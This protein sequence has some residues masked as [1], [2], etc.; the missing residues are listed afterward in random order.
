MTRYLIT[1]A[2]P[3]I[4]GVK[5]LGNLVGSMLPADVYARYLRGRGRNVFYLCAT[6]EHGTPAELA[7]AEEGVPVSEYCKRQY[8]IQ[9]AIYQR[10]DLSFDYF[11]RTS[12]AHNHRTTQYI[13]KSLRDRGYIDRRKIKQLYS[14]S[15]G[16]FLPDRYVMGT[17]PKCGDE[18]ARGD[19]CDAC[20]SLL[21][22]TDLIKPRSAVS[23]SFD[24]KMRETEH[25]YLK[26]SAFEP[27]LRE[28]VNKHSNWPLLTRSVALKWLN[29][30]LRARC[31]TRDLQW[32]VP[33]PEEN[34]ANKVFY[35]WFDAPIG[36]ISA[37]QEWAESIGEPEAW[38]SW[39]ES[40]TDVHYT[41]FM[42]KDNLPFHTVFFPAMLMGTGESW[43][44]PD[45]IKAFNWLT[46]EG[47]KFS[48]R[49]NRGVFLDKAIDLFPADYWRWML[50]AAAPESSDS[51]FTWSEF[52]NKVNK[53][54]NDRLG[55]QV[56][57]VLKLCAKQFGTIVPEGGV[58][59][60]EEVELEA[61]T[62]KLIAQIEQHYEK[63]EFRY[64]TQKI[65]ELWSLGNNYFDRCV[66]WKKELKSER[67]AVVLRTSINLLR[68][69]A[70]V[71]EPII[72]ESSHVIQACLGE[73]KDAVDVWKEQKW[74]RAISSGRQFN[75]PESLFRKVSDREVAEF[76]MRFAGLSK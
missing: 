41:Q 36:Y 10:F 73:G 42:A 62:G 37:A 5:H 2:L 67:R 20:L 31:I 30:G 14:P 49:G 3:Y 66:P 75:V 53:D 60:S 35:V 70:L 13:Y 48:T 21:E 33:V 34:M 47:D 17:C 15:D 52:Q 50:L 27:L 16:R 56:F 28:W 59:G 24:L 12:S 29:E 4:N 68:L 46:Y 61:K 76:T 18:Q 54:L 23:G 44:Q 69:C 11:G 57:R 9:K 45:M 64:L 22:P 74:I 32:G 6:D 58:F 51:S 40:P 71:A 63:L 1:S 7:A 25:L 43:K 39:W 65:A 38:R 26:L 19:Q 55:N 8:D 72:P